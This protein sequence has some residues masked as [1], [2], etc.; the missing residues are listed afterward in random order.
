MARATLSTTPMARVPGRLPA[1]ASSF[2]GRTI[3]L[4]SVTDALLSSRLVTLAGPG[5]VGKTRVALAAVHAAGDRLG[6]PVFVDLTRIPEGAPVALAVAEAMGLRGVRREGALDAILWWLDGG[7]QVLVVLDNAEHVLEET[8]ALVAELLEGAVDCTLLVTSRQPLHVAGEHT[9]PVGPMLDDDAETLF[10]ERALAVRPSLSVSTESRSMAR[11]L[12]VRLDRLPL[13]VEL[14]AARMSVMTPA[15]MLPMLESRL[16]D[17]GSGSATAP[18]RHRTLR[19]CIAASVDSLG[20]HERAAFEAC[21]VFASPFDARAAAAVAGASLENLEDLVTRSLLQPSVDSA[22]HTVFRLLE[23][24]REFAR[25]GLDAGRLEE[26]QRRHLAWIAAEFGAERPLSVMERSRNGQAVDRLPDVRAALDFAVVAAPAEG[27]RIMGATREL[28][29][30]SAQDEGLSRAA[31]L[32]ERHPTPDDARAEGLVTASVCHTSR[33]ETEAGNRLAGEALA[34]LDRDSAGAAAAFFYQAI[35]RCLAKDTEGS[36]ESCRAALDVYTKLG[37]TAGCSRAVG[38]LGM[39]A[40]WAHRDDDAIGILHEALDLAVAAGDL[41]AQGQILTYLGLAESNLG[42]AA[43]GRARLLEGVNAFA[44]VGDISYRGVALARLAALTVARDPTTAV[45]AAAATTRREGAGGRFHEIA[46]ADFA[47]VRSI[48]ELLLGSQSFAAAWEAGEKLSFAEAAE[49]LRAVEGGLQPG[50][51]TPREL[52]IV[53]LIRR[54][55][56]NASIARQ[57]SLSVRTVENH[58]AH[59]LTKLGLHSRSS[60]AV[61]AAEHEHREPRA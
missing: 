33:Q 52:E 7:E 53:E 15:E 47:Q 45:R 17:V 56:G 8:A 50:M 23:S 31:G 5:G 48:A 57:L 30:R 32:L 58:V 60:L 3:E 6:H 42:R 36:V 10:W 21:A 59:A 2:V 24:L 55:L 12:C 28:W 46:L 61:W 41:W 27:L 11:E 16:L 35:A 25:E 22:G 54:G 29:F 20:K 37:D 14:A 39:A 1:S 44:Q 38:M 51:L 49:E 40:V 4:A 43:V 26:V 19:A 13:A 9:I 34:I 18:A